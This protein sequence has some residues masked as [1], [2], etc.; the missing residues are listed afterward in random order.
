MRKIAVLSF[1][2]L[3]GV[4]QA[5]GAPGEDASDGFEYGG[6]VAPFFGKADNAAGRLMEM[7]MKPS[8]LL[9]GR[10]TFEIFAGYWPGHADFWLGINDVTKYVM[11]HTM[12]RSDWQHSVFLKSLDDIKKLKDSE[13]GTS[14]CTAVAIWSRRCSRTT[15]SMSYGSR[16]SRSHWAA[17]SACLVRVPGLRPLH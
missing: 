3:D 6:W 5:P 4:M 11:S 1:I 7:Q 2:S 17:A 16:P 14:R 12:D 8:D 10:K 13:G 9:L 15:W